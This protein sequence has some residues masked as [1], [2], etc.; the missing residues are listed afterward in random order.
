MSDNWIYACETNELEMD[1]V[2]GLTIED[3]RIAVY[4]IKEGY[5][6][7]DGL[8]S[9]EQADMTNGYVEG[10]F[11]ECPKHNARF[12]I[13]TGE[14]LRRPA[15]DGIKTYAVKIEKGCIYLQLI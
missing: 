3:K 4:Q 1:D 2:I 14:A 13:I 10:D 11:V 15:C 5:F 7:T 8:C 9:H 12:S 6:A